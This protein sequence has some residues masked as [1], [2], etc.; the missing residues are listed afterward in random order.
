[1]S[2]SIN[3]KWIQKSL[4]NV[5][6]TGDDNFVFNRTPKVC[7]VVNVDRHNRMITLSDTQNTITAFLT[8]H[9]INLYEQQEHLDI[10]NLKY[11]IVKIETYF[12]TTHLLASGGKTSFHGLDHLESN[13]NQFALQIL[14]FSCLSKDYQPQQS[15]GPDVNKNN[16]IISAT[17]NLGNYLNVVAKLVKSQFPKENYLPNSEGKF[18]LQHKFSDKN[19]IKFSH[20][21]EDNSIHITSKIAQQ[22]SQKMRK[23]QIQTKQIL[24]P[25]IETNDDGG[26]KRTLRSNNNSTVMENIY[27]TG[28]VRNVQPNKKMNCRDDIEKLLES[29]SEKN[30]SYANFENTMVDGTPFIENLLH[31]QIANFDIEIPS[32]IDDNPTKNKL[33]GDSNIS[34][35]QRLCNSIQRTIDYNN[36]LSQSQ[37]IDDSAVVAVSNV[38]Q[39]SVNNKIHD[40]STHSS[41]ITSNRQQRTVQV[42]QSALKSAAE[43]LPHCHVNNNKVNSTSSDN[44]STFNDYDYPIIQICDDGSRKYIH[45]NTPMYTHGCKRKIGDNNEDCE[46]IYCIVMSSPL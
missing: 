46:C 17:R 27:V 9:C 24:K 26:R 40:M 2:R 38:H 35:R 37:T 11:A 8:N 1:M 32:Q 21:F 44:D 29:T 28:D 19:P 31:T 39:E 14:K 25:T 15:L 34:I 30:T 4:K 20:C 18:F 13:L 33:N 5:I 7:V 41:S 10:S 6:H 36:L 45:K 42:N 23:N 12:F 3:Q 22:E 16:E 43:N